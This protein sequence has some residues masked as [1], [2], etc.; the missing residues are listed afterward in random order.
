V[1][2]NSKTVQAEALLAKIKVAFKAVNEAQTELVSRST[3]V[4]KLLLEAKKLYPKVKDFEAFLKRVDGLHLSRAYD[5]LRLAGGRTTDEELRE[6][7]RNRKRKS[8]AKPKALPTPEPKQRTEPKPEPERFRDV[9]ESA[10]ESAARRKA[11]NAQTAEE[12]TAAVSA[13][14]LRE[15][16]YA[17][18]TYLRS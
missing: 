7:A 4:G 3:V 16:Q 2:D 11:D 14:N 5:L 9:T 12:K 10:K 6:E 8:R 13:H 1:T 15:F 17:C 18:N